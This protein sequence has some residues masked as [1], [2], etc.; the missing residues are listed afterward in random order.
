MIAAVL[1]IAI[2]VAIATLVSGWIS[3][4][5][6]S[7]QIAAENKTSEAVDCAAAAVVVDDV[8]VVGTGSSA[9]VRAIVRNAGQASDLV[10]GNATVF[11]S[12]GG[13][14]TATSPAVPYA[15]FDRGESV[16]FQFNPASIGS[17]PSNFGEVIVTT[18]CGGVFAKFDKTPKCV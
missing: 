5:T 17:C 4:V 14:F 10:L 18:T 8:Y 2:T 13:T 7:S 16:T 3:T 9:T 15:D 6:R 1:L 12:S 11:N